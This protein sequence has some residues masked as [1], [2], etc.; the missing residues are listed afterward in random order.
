MSYKTIAV[1]IQGRLYSI[2]TDQSEDEAHLREIAAALNALISDA[3]SSA[4]MLPFSEQLILVGLEQQDQLSRLQKENDVLKEENAAL[5][6]K[7]AHYPLGEAL[8][9]VADYRDTIALLNQR[10]D[11]LQREN[12][13]LRSRL[14]Q[15]GKQDAEN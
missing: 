10:C 3:V 11:T 14:A 7:L 8:G 4:P 9:C 5:A 1:K 12:A 2:S 13:A 15:D 6:D